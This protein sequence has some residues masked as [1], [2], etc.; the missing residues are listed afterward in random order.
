MVKYKVKD[1]VLWRVIEDDAVLLNLKTNYYYSLNK[2]GSLILQ[3]LND[4]KSID[5]VVEYLFNYYDLG[6]KC[7]IDYTGLVEFIVNAMVDMKEPFLGAD[8]EI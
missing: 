8:D 1:S 7:G 2:S 5:E 4:G 3:E 6:T